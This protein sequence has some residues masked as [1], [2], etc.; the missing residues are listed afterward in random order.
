MGFIESDERIIVMDINR[1]SYFDGAP[2]YQLTTEEMERLR[3]VGVKTVL[4]QMWWGQ[5]ESGGRCKW[6]AVDRGIERAQ[7]A[8]IKVLLQ[9]Y[10][11]APADLPEE[12]YAQMAGGTT[13]PHLSIWNAE[14]SEYELQF[15]QKLARRY[16]GQDVLLINSLISDGETML[17][18]APDTHTPSWYDPAGLASYRKHCGDGE[19]TVQ[20]AEAT[21]W[22]RDSMVK[23]MIDYQGLLMGVQDHN[24]IWM[25]MHPHIFIRATGTQY[26]HDIWNA[27]CNTYPG[28][29]RQWLLYTFYELPLSW[30]IDQTN[31]AQQRGIGLTVGAQHVD[32]LSRT[33][34]MAKHDGVNLICGP[35]HDNIL[36][37]IRHISEPMYNQMAWAVGELNG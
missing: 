24:E 25:S 2:D 34:P 33:V 18:Y 28:A 8:G 30:Q 32:G 5:I 1:A 31:F 15:V 29:V 27:L 6:A 20:R 9:C 11:T 21:N 17:A 37:E 16:A 26:T 10:Q 7:K 13:V 12:W 19:V 3:D 22:L 36:P 14:A 4:Q 35:R 23:K